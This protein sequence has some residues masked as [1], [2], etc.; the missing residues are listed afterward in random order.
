MA[1][2]T[3]FARLNQI[4]PEALSQSVFDAIERQ[5]FKLSFALCGDGARLTGIPQVKISLQDLATYAQS[6]TPLDAPVE[7]YLISICPAVWTRAAD[8]GAYETREFDEANPD[9]LLPGVWLDELVLVL[10]S[11]VAR[12]KLEQGASVSPAELAMLS[13]MAGDAV[14]DLCRRGEIAATNEDGWEIE[15]EEAKRFLSTRG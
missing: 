7:E 14:R 12:E 8:S 4:N 10:R 15:A 1:P 2:P 5:I 3:K 9:K 6:G 11:A 13:S